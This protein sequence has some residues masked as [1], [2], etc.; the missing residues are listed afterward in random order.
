MRLERLSVH[1][2]RC[3]NELTIDFDPSMTVITAENGAGKTAILEAIAIGFG[4]LLMRLPGVSG[5]LSQ[6]TDIRLS[7]HEKRETFM[8]IEWGVAHN[9]KSLTWSGTRRR[10]SGI[11]A[12]DIKNELVSRPDGLFTQGFTQLNELAESLVAQDAEGK[13]FSLPVVAYYG[14]ERAVRDEVR[15][16]RG[17][18]KKFSRFDALA[19]ALNP[20][21]RFKSAFEWFHVMEDMER[22]EK[23]A[24]RDF[25]Y[26]QP[27]LE[28]VR[29]AI[30]RML[31]E[32]FSQ[33]RT[34]I[35][36]LRFVIDRVLE[37]GDSKTLRISEL[38]DGFRVVLGLVMD[39][40]RRLAQANSGVTNLNPLEA[41]A[42][43][44]IDE[45]DLHL[46]PGWQQH[47]LADLK[48]TFPGTQ[49]IVTT[50][51]PQVLSTVRRENI[52]V[53]GVGHDGVVT[54]ST[55]LAMTYGEPSGDVLHSVMQV[56]PQPPV[57]EK[58]DL[59][60]LTEIVDLGD[61]DSEEAKQLMG[62]L[63]N[64]LGDTHPQLLRLKRSIDRKRSFKG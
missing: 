6:L 11:K 49:F 23:E 12:S 25:D 50:H 43:A 20:D 13:A 33:P 58:V 42:I 63:S 32:G 54:A 44:L 53:I 56:D 37:N 34:E 31:P 16:R 38:S 48:R 59:D 19:G 55:P 62:R 15:T 61:Y 8:A 57:A 47:I 22:R 10:D 7:H 36:P 35:R 26:R 39:F 52:R 46:H 14:T 1:N 18:K 60:R 17:F 5:R 64:L 41:P 3:F 40:A 51:S 21:A 9:D 45:V 28:L 24:R 27:E 2:F 4:R 29:D 30:V